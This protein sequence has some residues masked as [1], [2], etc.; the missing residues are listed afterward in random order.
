MQFLP[1]SYTNHAA[2]SGG[3]VIKT[4]QGPDAESR[5]DREATTLAALTDLLPVP[6][7]IAVTGLQV[8]MSLMPGLPGQDLIDAGLA[9]QVMRACGQTLRRL[10]AT[11]AT[12]AGGTAPHVLVHGDYGPNNVLLDP[13]A[14]RVTA[15]V[16]WEWVHVGDPV[17][18]LAWAEWIVRMHHPAEVG[19]VAELFAGY[20]SRP[21]WAMR[22]QSMLT[23][24]RWHLANHE[25]DARDGP[26]AQKWRNFLAETA[27]WVE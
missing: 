2:R 20:G 14:S 27:T 3:I 1:H 19:A 11:P 17:E 4:Y 26:A 16:D 15:I 23:K 9:P 18:D 22:H 12:L 10:Q 6:R 25:R 5:R 7:L 8:R 13:T 24:C 21:S